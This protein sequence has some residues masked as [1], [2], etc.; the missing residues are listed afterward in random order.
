MKRSVKAVALLA[1]LAVLFGGYVLITNMNDK[2]QVTEQSGTFALTDKTAVDFSGIAWT[3][4]DA[5]YHFVVSNDGWRNADDD[6]FPVNQSAVQALADSLLALQA[7]RKLE[8][9]GSL[10]DYGLETPAFAVMAEWADGTQTHYQMGDATP[11]SD[12]YYMN[13]SGDVSLYTVA[14][15]LD[16]MFSGTLTDFAQLEEMPTAEGASRLAVGA[17]LDVS[18]RK[19][20]VTLNADQHWYSTLDGAALVDESVEALIKAVQG[21]AWNTMVSVGASDDELMMWQLT[22]GMA[23][24]LTLYGNGESSLALLIGAQH[25]SG[26]YYARLPD[27]DM[28][29][30]V[31]AD[32]LSGLLGANTAELLNTQLIALAFEDLL[33]AECVSDGQRWSIERTDSITDTAAEGATD[34]GDDGDSAATKTVVTVNGNAVDIVQIESLWTLIEGLKATVFDP[35]D[36]KE[37]EPLLSID[38]YNTMGVNASFAFY[39]Y[40]AQSYIAQ[41][42]DGTEALVSADTVD[43]ILRTLKQL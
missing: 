42:S 1:A 6:G 30:T 27:S 14:S 37:G 15:S 12:G 40:N 4:A 3:N 18:Y 7:N 33:K 38:V 29:Y 13:L 34:S 25:D 39:A 43:K 41:T 9:I 32:S 19:T 11:F 31:A 16:D 8:N 22:D 28:V 26:G 5:S 2:T 17:A 36:A 35:A 10:A 21:L 23:T 24:A 20:S